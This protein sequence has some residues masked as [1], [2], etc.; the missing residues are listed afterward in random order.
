NLESFEDSRP[1]RRLITP[2]IKNALRRKEIALPATAGNAPMVN[3]AMAL[4]RPI[5]SLGNSE[6]SE[7]SSGSTDEADACVIAAHPEAR[8]LPRIGLYRRWTSGFSL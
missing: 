1:P 5:P 3:T 7:P 8:H 6:A 2:H 4:L